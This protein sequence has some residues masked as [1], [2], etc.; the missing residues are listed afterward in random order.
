MPPLPLRHPAVLLVVLL[1]AAIAVLSVTYDAYDPDQWQHFT[2]GRYIWEQHRL[3]TTELWTWP[4]YGQ[5]T[6]DYAW[7]FEALVW[8]FWK[9]GGL[10]GLYLWRWLTTLAAF[11][12]AWAAARRM[13][14]KGLA[15]LVAVALALMVY[16]G[17]SQVRPETVAAILLAAEI[18]LLESRRHGHKVHAAWLV[19]IAWI[20]ANAHISYYLFFVVLGVHVLANLLAR[21]RPGVPPVREL[22][23]AGLACAAVSFVNPSGWRTLWQPFEFFFVWRHEPIY[24]HIGEMGPVD[25]SVNWKNG[26]PLLLVLWPLLALARPPRRGDLAGRAGHD[27]V[28]LMLCALFSVVLLLGQRFMGTYALVAAVYVGRDLDAW[29]RSLARPAWTRAPWARG[30]LAAAACLVVVAPELSRAEVPIRMRLGVTHFPIGACDYIQS[31]GLKGRFYNPFGYGGYICYRFW[32]DRERLPFMGIHQEGDRDTRFL[33]MA[34]LVNPVYWDRLDRR[35]SFDV[36]ILMRN[37]A[38]SDSLLP[39]VDADASWARLFG[40]DVAHVYVRRDGPFAELARDSAYRVLPAD[41]VAMQ[42]LGARAEGDTALLRRLEGELWREV[43]G[44]PYHAQALAV[45]ANVSAVE[46]HWDEAER[47]ARAALAVDDM[48]PRGRER[49][50][51]I[52][53]HEG[54]PREALRWFEDE[55]RVIGWSHGLDLR[56]GQ[57]AQAE[58][59]LERARDCYLR[60]TRRAPQNAEARDSLASVTR[61]L[62]G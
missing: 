9:L 14:A 43:A 37:T 27:P 28:E 2:V 38:P 51:L 18:W 24:A 31:H 30:A 3:P 20:W 53:L 12:F 25:G 40:D 23:L 4:T 5:K 45:L 10:T 32:P 1:V 36:L 8:P 48:L 52:L 13:G 35:F 34:A 17:R 46:G 33:Y 59:D 54:R 11:G 29:A 47:R 57:V 42:A 44:S 49:L 39:A 16:R 6:V 26:L 55:Y 60:E 21:K 41:P 62:G 61:R 22:W 19:P 7:G 56:R 15:P 50:G 58:G